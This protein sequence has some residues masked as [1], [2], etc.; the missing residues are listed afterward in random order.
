M[1]HRSLSSIQLAF[2]YLL[3]FS[4]ARMGEREGGSG[5]GERKE[6]IRDCIYMKFCFLSLD[7][8]FGFKDFSGQLFQQKFPWMVIIKA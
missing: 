6:R 3:T 5:E 1:I 4:D 2:I 7:F 8:L